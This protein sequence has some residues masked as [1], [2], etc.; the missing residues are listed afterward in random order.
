MRNVSLSVL[1]AAAVLAAACR[2]AAPPAPTPPAAVVA[3]TPP[4]PPPIDAA[5]RWVLLLEA[6]GQAIEVIMDLTKISEG[7]YG[8]SASSQVFPPVQLTKAS[9]AGNRLTIHSPAPT[10]DVAV[11]NLIIEGDLLS[12]D[13]SMPGMGS[14]VTGRRIP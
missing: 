1:L 2:P 4:P 13:W 10:G 7:E 5:G 12:G 11:F 9:L 14:R 6:Q 3:P 8:G